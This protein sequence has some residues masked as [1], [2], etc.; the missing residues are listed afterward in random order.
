[1]YIPSFAVFW[2]TYRRTLIGLL[3]V[4]LILVTGYFAGWDATVVTAVAALV[5]ILTQAFAGLLGLV[6]LVPWIGPLIA[7]ALAIPLVWLLNGAGYFFSAFLAGRGHGK[8]VVQSRVL[9]VVLI[10]GIIIGF[11]LGKIIS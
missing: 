2:A 8:S 9:T 3:V 11:I 1:M 6:A 10:V 4:V 5:G 7:K